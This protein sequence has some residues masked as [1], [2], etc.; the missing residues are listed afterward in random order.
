MILKLFSYTVDPLYFTGVCTVGT[1]AQL[2]LDLAA[3]GST[4]TQNVVHVT[5]L[6]TV[7]YVTN[8]TWPA[9]WSYS[10]ISVKGW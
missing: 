9:S 2:V 5:A 8:V 10:A 7:Q 4:T 6:Q 1:V 3:S